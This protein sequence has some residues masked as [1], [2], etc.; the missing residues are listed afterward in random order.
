MVGGGADPS[1][2]EMFKNADSKAFDLALTNPSQNATL[3]PSLCPIIVL[4]AK[5]DGL[6]TNGNI[7]GFVN[8][9]FGN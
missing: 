7:T 2:I 8:C 9:V 3:I 6:F 4:D 1:W 5:Y